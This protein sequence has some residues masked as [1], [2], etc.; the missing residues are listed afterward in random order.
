MPL[1]I[2]IFRQNSKYFPTPLSKIYSSYIDFML[3]F[4]LTN[5]LFFNF[6]MFFSLVSFS[7]LV[8]HVLKIRE[9]SFS[10]VIN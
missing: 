2:A 7:F 9:V 10:S 3:V 4:S 1:F 6:Q 5:P 8:D